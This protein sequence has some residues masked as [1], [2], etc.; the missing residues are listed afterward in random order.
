LC[1]EVMRREPGSLGYYV[2]PFRVMAKQIAWDMLLRATQGIRVAKNESELTVT[3]P[4]HRKIA[5]KG[6]DDPETLEG[7][8]LVAA[9][10]DEFAR[11]KLAAWEK[12]LR[13]ALSDKRGRVLFCGKPRGHNHLKAFY[14]RGQDGPQKADGWRSWL[15][16]TAQGGNVATSDIGEARE[17]LPSKV[18]RQ[19]YEATFETAAGRIYEDFTRRAHVVP[20]ETIER[21]WCVNGRWRFRQ[22]LVGT[23]WGYSHNGVML[24]VGVTGGGQLVV[25]HEEVHQQMLVTESGWLGVARRLTETFGVDEFQCDPSEPG[26]IRALRDVFDRYPNVLVV[27]ADNAVGAGILDVQT[28]LLPMGDRPGLIVSDRCT[29]TIREFESYVFREANGIPS[30]EPVKAD[31]HC[32]DALRYAVRAARNQ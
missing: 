20:H 27:N 23:D 24:V 1:I 8:G 14:E 22:I 16:T 6:A 7:V 26:N 32:M 19:E 11:M 31:D 2:A 12:S 18:Y 10:L 25:I 3:L 17:T 29:H 5:L 9:V 13:P 30:E 4:G 28:A 21:E 15:F